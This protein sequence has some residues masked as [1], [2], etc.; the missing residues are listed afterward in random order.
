MPKD[1]TAEKKPRRKIRELPARV[2]A[3]TPWL[4]RRYAR[5]LVRMMK[6]SRAKGRQLPVDLVRVERQIRSLPPAVQAQRLEEMLEFGA[7]RDASSAS[8][9][10][11]RAVERQDRRS[12]KGQ[13][14]VRPGLAPGQRRR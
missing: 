13:G 12:G 7:A 3:R 14:G 1:P 8:R 2:I 10:L 9:E 4:R 11:R 6:K 5:Y